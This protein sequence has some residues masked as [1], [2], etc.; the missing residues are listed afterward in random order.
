M[1]YIILLALPSSVTLVMR[2]SEVSVLLVRARGTGYEF[3]E[4][5]KF[6]KLCSS[7]VVVNP[8]FFEYLPDVISLQLC[9]PTPAQIVDV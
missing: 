9:T 8:F 4:P 7:S 2:S 1:C 5:E 6:G 3:V